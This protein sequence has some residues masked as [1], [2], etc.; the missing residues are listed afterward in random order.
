LSDTLERV[1]KLEDKYDKLLNDEPVFM[2]PH[3]KGWIKLKIG[4]DGH[5]L[6]LEHEGEPWQIN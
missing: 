2:C 6:L 1:E 5:I 3:C 4:K